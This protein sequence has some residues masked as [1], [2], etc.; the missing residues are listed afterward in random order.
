MKDIDVL[1]LIE[2]T[3]RELDVAC[4]VK[5]VMERE[6]GLR[7]EIR[8]MYYHAEDSLRELRPRVVAYPFF[9]F[10]KNAMG[11][12]D[13]VRTWP[14]A[15]HF[16]LSWEQIHYKAHWKIKS[17]SDEFA[18]KRVV[19]HAWG[20]FYRD[21][22]LEFN[23]D[24][25]KIFVNGHPAY[26]LYREPYRSHY[27]DRATLAMKYGLDL[28]KRWI[29]VPENYRWAFVGSKTKLF[30][31]LGG[32]LDEIRLLKTFCW[33]SL[34]KLFES[35]NLLAAQPD[36]EVIFRTRPAID[37]IVMLDSF[38]ETVGSAHPQVHFIKN[39]SIR[40]WI[41]A[42]DVV[43]SSY[44]TSLIEA[45]I[46]GKQAYMFA[47]IPIPESLHCAWYDLAPVVR[48]AE[49]MVAV[50]LS[51]GEGHIDPLRQW[52]EQSMLVNGDP[53]RGLAGELARLASRVDN[54]RAEAI[55]AN[56]EYFNSKTHENDVISI[57]ELERRVA[58]WQATIDGKP[59]RGL[60][61]QPV[62]NKTMDRNDLFH[63][64]SRKIVDRLDSLIRRMYSEGVYMSS[65][66]GTTPPDLSMFAEVKRAGF[67]GRILDFLSG[68]KA[69]EMH[70]GEEV[71]LVRGIDQRRDYQ[72]L[73]G[74]ADDVRL[75]WFL[76]WEICWVLRM[77][78]DRLTPQSRVLDAGGSGSLFS[79]Y[80]SSLG[81][82]VHAI[83]LNPKLEKL[84]RAIQDKMG[85]NLY[86]YTMNMC[87]LE[88]PDEYFDHA[89]SICV[90]EHLDIEIKR[91]AL[92]EIARCLRPGGIFAI[93][94]DYKTPAPGIAG[95][96]K[97]PRPRN[98]LKNV[99]DIHRSF[100]SN[101]DFELVGNQD[102]QDN[103]TS[104]LI[105]PKYDNAPYTFGSV[106]LRKK[107]N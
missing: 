88:F 97:D 29:F 6:H 106:F 4:L 15:V 95:Y 85:F 49:E 19:H 94:F 87:S 50:C 57:D 98:Q 20:K 1:Y 26:M 65:W 11:T 17:P 2:H 70:P 64:D 105:H 41:L 48:S 75:P 77:L 46:A 30:S 12:E 51:G 66:V 80:L 59:W 107:K 71:A 44:S 13:Y 89:F 10:L 96:G 40:E 100:L 7:V 61:R 62:I 52:A 43:V 38:G 34:V 84:G 31:K 74:A 82:E 103:G 63:P 69:P 9:Y 33:E 67:L 104:Y 55:P 99:A 25:E 27:C 42:S 102:F 14:D 60:V 72:P 39:E 24:P 76:Y 35:C 47:P 53:I 92:S 93:T 32:N 8:N 101:P 81:T 83:D 5:A 90:F 22:L 58:A 23:V 21:Y 56:V 3:S 18:R 79:C 86:S 78:G 91:G 36:V 73:P 54:V 68:A 45:A 16:N 37:S 28:D